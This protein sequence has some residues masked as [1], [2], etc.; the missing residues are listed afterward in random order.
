MVNL[1]NGKTPTEFIIGGLID[2]LEKKTGLKV[3]D[4]DITEDI[5]RPCI[6]LDVAKITK[7]LFGH[8]PHYNYEINVY[9][10]AD[11]MYKGYADYIKRQ[12]K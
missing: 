6:I 7:D 10:F 12:R 8:M 4:R 3:L 5:P 1:I 9:Y 11:S 2:Y